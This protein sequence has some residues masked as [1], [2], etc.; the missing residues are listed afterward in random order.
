MKLFFMHLT[1]MAFCLGAV[2]CESRTDTEV[3]VD[4]AFTPEDRLLQAINQGDAEAATR[5]LQ[6]GADPNFVQKLS[7]AEND[8]FCLLQRVA[9]RGD[10][11]MARILIAHEANVNQVAGGTTPLHVAIT[12]LKVPSGGIDRSQRVE[13][14]ELLIENGADVNAPNRLGRTPLD[15]VD[16]DVEVASLL[17]A[18]GGQSTAEM[19]DRELENIERQGGGLIGLIPDSVEDLK[20]REEQRGRKNGDEPSDDEPVDPLIGADDEV[21]VPE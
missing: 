13:L 5:E 10:L 6:D 17:K 11:E 9:T 4:I 19:Q 8:E 18:R 14:I 16:G 2:G 7:D 15:M 12:M 1:V 20:R 21:R 3:P